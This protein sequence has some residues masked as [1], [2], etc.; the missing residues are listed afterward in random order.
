MLQKKK[1]G[2]KAILTLGTMA[3]L[4]GCS[5]VHRLESPHVVT[6]E[7]VEINVVPSPAYF[8]E[9]SFFY[10]APALWAGGMKP[11]LCNWFL[12]HRRPHIRQS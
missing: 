8:P 10:G 11:S 6:L 2:Q 9:V 12:Y 3:I 4:A 5:P 1:I 7:R